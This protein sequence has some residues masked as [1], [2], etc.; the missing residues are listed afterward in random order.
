MSYYEDNLETQK[1]KVWIKVDSDFR[2]ASELQSHLDDLDIDFGDDSRLMAR[3]SRK[4]GMY[5]T[6][7]PVPFRGHEA[8]Q[9]MSIL[10]TDPDIHEAG[11][12]NL[13]ESI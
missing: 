13:S 1:S 3:F 11:F 9:V 7:E 8:D 4:R 12:D 2:N 5:I 6:K 10:M